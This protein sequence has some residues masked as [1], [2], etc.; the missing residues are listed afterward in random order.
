VKSG[1]GKYSFFN[2]D[3][4]FNQKY[5]CNDAK[6]GISG[7][8]GMVCDKVMI[9][10]NQYPYEKFFRENKEKLWKD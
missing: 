3:F 1:I 5:N 9:D 8:F 4:T 10:E 7:M 2:R 6:S